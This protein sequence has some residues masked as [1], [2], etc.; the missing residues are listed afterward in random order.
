LIVIDGLVGL[1][2]HQI[3]RNFATLELGQFIILHCHAIN[4]T[5]KII[6]TA[7]CK[8]NELTYKSNSYDLFFVYYFYSPVEID[9]ESD[10]EEFE[11]AINA[12]DDYFAEPVQQNSRKRLSKF[13]SC[14]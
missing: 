14:F 13:D 10:V 6:S 3:Q 8:F 12:D 5:L 2:T 11:D 1:I 9:S 7:I 4:K